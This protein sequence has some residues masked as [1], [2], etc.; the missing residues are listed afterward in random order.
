MSSNG[1]IRASKENTVRVA[2]IIKMLPL[3]T[4]CHID[5]YRSFEG[6]G[7]AQCTMQESFITQNNS[8]ADI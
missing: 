8:P 7:Y 2:V 1:R 6:T 5:E 3:F 4:V